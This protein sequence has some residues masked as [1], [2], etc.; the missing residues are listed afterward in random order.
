MTTR[1]IDLFILFPSEFL[2]GFAFL[3]TTYEEHREET[4]EI[5]LGLF[6]IRFTKAT[7]EDEE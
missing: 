5:F 1:V 7:A 4:F 3:D 2:L 6:S